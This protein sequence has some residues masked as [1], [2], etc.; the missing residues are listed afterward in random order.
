MFLAALILAGLS[1]AIL[2]IFLVHGILIQSYATK[3]VDLDRAYPVLSML[4]AGLLSCILAAFGWRA[5]RLFL[6]G[7]GLVVTYLWYLAGMAASP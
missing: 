6:I 2:L 4:V 7:D 5:S 1:T 3:G